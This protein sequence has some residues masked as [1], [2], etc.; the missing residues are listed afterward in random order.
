MVRKADASVW[1]S[2]DGIFAMQ[3]MDLLTLP[4]ETLQDIA[5]HF[6]LKEWIQGPARTCHFLY[7]MELSNVD[8]TFEMQYLGPETNYSILITFTI[9]DLTS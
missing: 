8:L 2:V 3:D 5:R 7:A 1:G 4:E 6:T 9:P